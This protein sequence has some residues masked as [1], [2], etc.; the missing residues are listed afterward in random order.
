[1]SR[2]IP[3]TAIPKRPLSNGEVYRCRFGAPVRKW[4]R[5]PDGWIDREWVAG[6]KARYE[7]EVL[8]WKNSAE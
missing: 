4:V 1:M 2:L 3:L 5:T 6:E 7:A 8:G